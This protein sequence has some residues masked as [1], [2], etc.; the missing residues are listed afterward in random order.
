MPRKRP[1][2]LSSPPGE[3]GKECRSLSAPAQE[4]GDVSFEDRINRIHKMNE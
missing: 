3:R 4:F 1:F 2:T